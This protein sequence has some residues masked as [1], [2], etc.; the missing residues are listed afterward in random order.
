MEIKAWAGE[1][2]AAAEVP[3]VAFGLKIEIE[4]GQDRAIMGIEMLHG[5]QEHRVG[6]ERIQRLYG[7]PEVGGAVFRIALVGVQKHIYRCISVAMNK[8]L[9]LV[10]VN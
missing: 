7:G 8:Q 3:T 2:N 10:V 1:K 9:Q 4:V 6:I 5:P